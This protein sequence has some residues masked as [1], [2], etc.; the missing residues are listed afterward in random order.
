MFI[1]PLFTPI[2]TI[3]FSRQDFVMS[4]SSKSLDDK[5]FV[6][7]RVQ[8]GRP[9]ESDGWLWAER[10]KPDGL[11]VYVRHKA[12]NRTFCI[13]G[14]HPD[15]DTW[16]L[17]KNYPHFVEM[18]NIDLQELAL[19]LRNSNEEKI[20]LMEERN[21]AKSNLDCA[22]QIIENIKQEKIGLI[23]ELEQKEKAWL[24]AKN[25][26]L[27]CQYERQIHKSRAANLEDEIKAM[28]SDRSRAANLEDEIKAMRSERQIHK[29]RAANLED[30]IKAMHSD[31]SVEEVRIKKLML[32]NATL[33]ADLQKTVGEIAEAV[34]QNTKQIDLHAKQSMMHT[35][36]TTASLKTMCKTRG[37]SREQGLLKEVLFD[38]LVE[39]VKAL[40]GPGSP[41]ANP[42][43]R[44][45]CSQRYP[46][47]IAVILMQHLPNGTYTFAEIANALGE[48]PWRLIAVSLSVETLKTTSK[49]FKRKKVDYR[50]DVVVNEETT[51]FHRFLDIY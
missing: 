25:D 41:G 37:I 28:H 13:S 40:P 10:M 38:D 39:V 51:V 34:N 7:Y 36:L 21:I 50:G 11:W 5:S 43:F 4:H 29:S 35:E 33:L 23:D 3:D 15:A 42:K 16:Y 2:F 6:P 14:R 49:S 1:A 18:N 46:T 8:K 30:E 31:R 32:T 48:D 20:S 9:R 26:L 12:S 17:I 24:D 47:K 27:N 22:K 19:S 44:C 45:C